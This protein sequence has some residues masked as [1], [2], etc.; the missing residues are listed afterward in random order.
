MQTILPSALRKVA[1]V[2]Y[3]RER[4][5]TPDGDFLD[6]DW[7]GSAG[8]QRLLILSHGLEGSSDRP[9]MLGMARTFAEQGWRVLAWNLRGCSGE[10]NRLERF[11]HHGSTD[12]LAVVIQHALN[13]HQYAEVVLI[14][15][16]LGGNITLKYL[17]EQ[18]NNLPSVV[19]K[20]VAF[21]VPSDLVSSV[22]LLRQGAMSRF[23]GNRFKK[24]IMAKVMAK[25]QAGVIPMRVAERV[26]AL[27]TLDDLT[28]HYAAPLH[29]FRD[30]ADYYLRNSSLPLLPRIEI[31]TLILN[32]ANDPM[33]S[34]SC[35]PLELAARSSVIHVEVPEQG[36]HCGF[37]PRQLE[38]G[39][40][41]WSEQRARE[42]VLAH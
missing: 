37:R 15:F 9:Y 36:G 2:S 1:G 22:P 21:S 33:L 19:R 11:Y 23:Y 3:T 12:D 4:I 6:L 39:W 24:K 28:E 14:G 30:A 31:P 17:G 18:G 20:A 25:A 10:P 8:S 13:H 40:M 32:A 27:K 7:A 26:L 35:S 29:G 34:V 38:A 42:F 16:S 41:Y 5:E